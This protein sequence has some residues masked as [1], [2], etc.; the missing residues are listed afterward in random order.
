MSTQNLREY[1][2]REKIVINLVSNVD[3]TYWSVLPSNRRGGVKKGVDGA[4]VLI[5]VSCRFHFIKVH[6]HLA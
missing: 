5:L 4:M 3:I 6:N 2:D 1:Y